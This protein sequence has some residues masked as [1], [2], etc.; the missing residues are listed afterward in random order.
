[1]CNLKN[2]SAKLKI[3]YLLLLLVIFSSCKGDISDE[4]Y[5]NENY[6]FYQEEGKAGKWQKI[7][8]E[9]EIKLPKSHSTYF[10]PNGSRY[11]ELK[12]ID[13]FPNRI[14]KYFNKEDKLI[15]TVKFKSD[16]MVS[17]VFENGN[18][19]GYHSNLGFLQSEGLFENNMYQGNWKFYREDGKTL[20]QT[21]N[22]INDVSVGIRKDYWENGK[23]KNRSVYVNGKP[24]GQTIHYYESGK[25]KEINHLKNGEFHGPMKGF[26]ENGDISYLRNYWN[27]KRKDTCITYFKNG[28]IER[29]QIYDLDTLSMKSKGK[30]YV[31][32]DTGEL[33]LEVDFTG[34][35]KT[36]KLIVY[37]KNGVIIERSEKRNNKH[38]G[39]FVTYYDSGIKKL[40]GNIYDGYFDGKLNYYNTEGK[41][42]KTVNYD[43]GT[44][45]DSI[46]Y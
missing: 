4:K 14:I 7:N 31:Y 13:S 26:F 18:Y 36:G 30:E 23:L 20:K 9:L 22:Y 32:F 35:S 27:G 38:Q 28:E 10:F 15:R 11:A 5:R 1:V 39:A 16:S 24:N 41:I 46:M 3:K 6:V 25:L 33:K 40:E 17:K 21:A 44:V 8:P 12:V 19:R 34:Y 37:N 43:N 42:T 2:Q 45:L 29:L